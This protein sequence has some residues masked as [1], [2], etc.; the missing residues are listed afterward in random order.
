MNRERFEG[1]PS[2]EHE[3]DESAGEVFSQKHGGHNRNPREEIGSEF[4]APEISEEAPD[5]RGTP[6]N[7]GDPE[8]KV[9]SERF[10]FEAESQHEVSDNRDE[11]ESGNEKLEPVRPARSVRLRFCHAMFQRDS[12][13]I[14]SKVNERC[15]V[16]ISARAS[17]KTAISATLRWFE[18]FFTD[19]IAPAQARDLNRVGPFRHSLV[20]VEPRS[21]PKI[22]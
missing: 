1:F 21:P 12:H 15:A 19:G 5:E 20:R 18:G 11:R 13:S 3:D 16:I 2:G 17:G 4:A 10:E 14:R 7:V 8:R 9:R 6:Q 22:S